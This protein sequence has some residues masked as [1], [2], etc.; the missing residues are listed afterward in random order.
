MWLGACAGQGPLATLAPGLLPGEPLTTGSLAAPPSGRDLALG[1]RGGAFARASLALA[2]A[3]DPM[4]GGEVVSWN[5]PESGARGTIAAAGPPGVEGALVCRRFDAR[6]L[7]P[8]GVAPT[9]RAVRHEGRA[10][11]VAARSWRIE[12]AVR[13]DDADDV[14]GAH[15][16]AAPAGPPIDLQIDL[17]QRPSG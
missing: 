2:D 9:P 11:R 13:A 3:L 17:P 12:E 16:D 5:D 14:D 15:A 6:T 4:G 10:C 1:L 8:G 7:A